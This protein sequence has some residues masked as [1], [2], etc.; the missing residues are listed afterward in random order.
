ME[1]EKSMEP[2]EVYVENLTLL[3]KKKSRF[4]IV[5]IIAVAVTFI[6]FGIYL[7]SPLSTVSILKLDGNIYFTINDIYNILNC[8]ENDSIYDKE[9]K[10]HLSV[11]YNNKHKSR[12]INTNEKNVV[13]KEIQTMI[14][15]TKENSIKIYTYPKLDLL[16][17]N[18]KSK[19]KN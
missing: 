3:N 12:N 9:E 16:N 14:N 2:N 11:D 5:R 10:V 6:V 15:T 4:L 1:K 19:M 8:D 18:S 17:N 13:N 7:L